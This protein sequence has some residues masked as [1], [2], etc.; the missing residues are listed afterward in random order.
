MGNFLGI[1]RLTIFGSEFPQKA[2]ICSSVLRIPFILA[3]CGCLS[4]LQQAYIGLPPF[5]ADLSASWFHAL[6]VTTSSQ[7]VGENARF[8]AFRSPA[9]NRN[10]IAKTP[11][12]RKPPGD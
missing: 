8:R 10:Y 9:F 12:L 1:A 6:P 7:I 11:N 2:S 3:S 4:W 5:S